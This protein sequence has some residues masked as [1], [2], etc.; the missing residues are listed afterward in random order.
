[1][2]YATQTDIEELYGANALYVA[3]RDGD[4]V[5]D[6]AAVTRALQLASG[7]IDSFLGV[8]Y[9]VPLTHVPEIVG[10]AC[11]DIA[12]YRLALSADVLSEEHRRRYEDTIAH[13]KRIA[14]GEA[15]LVLPAE[16]LVEGEEPLPDGPQPIVAGGPEK[17]WTRDKTRD[18]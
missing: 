8:R 17:L 13:L 6:V 9:S 16:P 15:M 3:D 18:L 11:V 10:Q 5:A 7:E 2:A 14:K 1:M 4:G 12:L